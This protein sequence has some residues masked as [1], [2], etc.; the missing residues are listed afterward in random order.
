MKSGG[1]TASTTT[2]SPLQANSG[3]SAR[4]TVPWDELVKGQIVVGGLVGVLGFGFLV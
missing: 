3:R 1:A 2:G 4:P